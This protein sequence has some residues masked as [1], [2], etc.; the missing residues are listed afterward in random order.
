MAGICTL[1]FAWCPVVGGI[2]DHLSQVA[3]SGTRSISGRCYLMQNMGNRGVKALAWLAK[4]PDACF[5][6]GMKHD[7][8]P[9]FH[10][11]V[12]SYCLDISL[13]SRHAGPAK[14]AH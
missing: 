1:T 8:I 4:C 12:Q 5:V 6:V 10:M 14:A 13:V 2:L 7:A 3:S 9:S 11:F